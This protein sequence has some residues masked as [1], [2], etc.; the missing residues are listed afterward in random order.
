VLSKSAGGLGAEVAIEAVDASH[1]FELRAGLVRPAAGWPTSVCTVSWMDEM[2]AAYDVFARPR[3][4]GAL[5][6]ALSPS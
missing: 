5:K 6:V 3:E 4:A 2:P 1:G